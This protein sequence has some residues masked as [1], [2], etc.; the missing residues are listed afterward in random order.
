MYLEA[1]V[2][3]GI[4]RRGVCGWRIR[5][6]SAWTVGGNG[7]QHEVCEFE[8]SPGGAPVGSDGP[9]LWSHDSGRTPFGDD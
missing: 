5:R 6:G 2:P 9:R 3:F 7:P 4:V 8:P 1:K